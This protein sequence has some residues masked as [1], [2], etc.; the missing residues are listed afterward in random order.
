[1]KSVPSIRQAK[2]E[3]T[4]GQLAAMGLANDWPYR[5][6]A[7]GSHSSHLDE[8]RHGTQKPRLGIVKAPLEKRNMGRP[9]LGPIGTSLGFL[10]PALP[11]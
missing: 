4:A 2:C 10:P 7:S 11:T 1:M 8:W 9:N 3:Q 6:G 5:P